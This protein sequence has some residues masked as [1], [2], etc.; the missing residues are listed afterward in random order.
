[1]AMRSL[2]SI[3]EHYDEPHLQRCCHCQCKP[4]VIEGTVVLK[5]VLVLLCKTIAWTWSTTPA[6]RSY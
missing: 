5:L 4:E 1:M 3:Q 2:S 6:M